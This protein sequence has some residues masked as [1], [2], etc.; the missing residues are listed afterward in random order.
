MTGKELLLKTINPN[1]YKKLSG[2]YLIFCIQNEKVYIGSSINIRK[3]FYSH[4][5]LLKKNKHHNNYLQNCYNKY[6]ENSLQYLVI[7]LTEKEKLR[8]RE[9]FWF[10]SVENKY[11]LNISPINPKEF[12][13]KTNISEDRKEILRQRC[14]NWILTPEQRKKI[15]DSK[16]GYK[17]TEEH[18][19]KLSIAHKGYKMPEEQKRKISEA[20]KG[21][22][23][24]EETKKKLSLANK[25]QNLGGKLSEETKKKIG[26]AGR[27]KCLDE[28]KRKIGEANK[29]YLKTKASKNKKEVLKLLKE[30]KTVSE[31]SKIY[32][33]SIS[34]IYL[35]I[36][37]IK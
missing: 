6:G 31:L 16:K 5:K 10:N 30:G 21:R 32:E 27:R 1:T 23:V 11:T 20:N 14:K 13:F 18:K 8:E 37:E 2:V 4:K 7:E 15:S 28:T 22:I 26:I 25:G 24:S 17:L 34:T 9:Q 12:I 35:I 3:R 36:K 29:K 33:C 19:K